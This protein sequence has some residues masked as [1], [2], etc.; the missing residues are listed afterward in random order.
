MNG[1][2]MQLTNIFNKHITHSLVM[3]TLLISPAH[4]LIHEGIEVTGQGHIKV[5]SDEF[6]LT[7]TIAER[8]KIPSK[9]KILVDKKINSVVSTAKQLSLKESNISTAGED[10]R[11]VNE[12][13]SIKLQGLEVKKLRKTNIYIDGQ[14]LNQQVS[15]NN[16]YQQPLFEFSR[17][18]SLSFN[19]LEQYAQFLAQIVKIR[20]SQVSSLSMGTKDREALYEKALE[21]A[22]SHAKEKALRL[23]KATGERLGKVKFIKELSAN[24][25]TTMNTDEIMNVST[26]GNDTSLTSSQVI[27]ARVLVKFSLKE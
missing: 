18:I 8:G 19:T 15:Q 7:L 16:N 22:I 2:N 25:P 6:S 23:A 20:V 9:L 24:Y 21:Q 27:T 5:K 12:K 4:A 3:L 13:P 10:L 1:E 17:Q 14:D 11:L 26:S